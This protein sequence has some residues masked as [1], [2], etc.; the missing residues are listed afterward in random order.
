M[1]NCIN[2]S[3]SGKNSTIFVLFNE[4]KNLKALYPKKQWAAESTQYELITLPP[5]TCSYGMKN[6]NGLYSN[7]TMKSILCAAFVAFASA[8]TL[9][10]VEI[11]NTKIVETMNDEESK[12]NNINILF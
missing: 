5:Q 6:Q 3:P 11:V 7:E 1:S 4:K 12:I 2:W 10:L 9:T 8:I